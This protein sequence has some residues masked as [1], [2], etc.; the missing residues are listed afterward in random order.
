MTPE[1]KS[2]LLSNLFDMLSTIAPKETEQ[3]EFAFDIIHAS[4]PGLSD[5][6]LKVFKSRFKD[7]VDEI[8]TYIG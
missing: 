7:V 1:A 3:L 8:Q 5:R 4:L 6:Q 2:N